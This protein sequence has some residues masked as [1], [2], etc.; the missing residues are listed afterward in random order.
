MLSEPVLRLQV[1]SHLSS[2]DAPESRCMVVFE[3][4]RQ[5]MNSQVAD[6]KHVSLDQPPV[7]VEAAQESAS[8]LWPDQL[9]SSP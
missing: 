3:E 1:P 8:M 5:L 6:Y 9:S 4:V 2:D 7:E